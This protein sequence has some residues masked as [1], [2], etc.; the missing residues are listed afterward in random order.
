MLDHVDIWVSGGSGGSGLVSFRR[1]KY[2]PRGGPDGGDGGRGGHVILLGDSSLRTLTVFRRRRRYTGKRGGD[3]GP[4]KRHGANGDDL[5]LHVP[6]GTIVQRVCEGG[7][8][9]VGD[10]ADAGARLVVA[11]GGMGGRGN[12][13]FATSTN[14]APRIAEKGQRGEEAHLILDLK[15]LSDVGIVGM[16]NAGKSTLL[17]RVSRARPKVASYPFTTLEPV[18]GVV[19]IGYES[20]VMADIPGII[21]G[22][23]EGAGL[24]HQFLR[25][26]ERT[27]V[28]VHLVDGTRPQPRGDIETLNAEMAAFNEELARKRQ[29]IVVNKLD[30]P[31]VRERRA[32]LERALTAEG[33]ASL[34][35]SAATGEGVDD[36]LRLLLRVLSAEREA[37]PPAEP[38]VV[39]PTPLRLRFKVT[40]GDHVYRVEGERA[41]AAVEMLGLDSDEAR[42]EVMRQLT[43]MGVVGALRR[44]GVQPGDR[45]HFGS[46]EMEW[47]E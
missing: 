31:E 40:G 6:V 34:F 37:A 47:Q 9:V 27:R 26:V 29:V 1:E 19:E 22:A 20:F 28:L 23:H 4:A 2:V 43:R 3:G 36:L 12:T 41:V 13:R 24:G 17:R 46:V 38:A 39:G 5:V 44:A 14:Q 10:I 35:I 16:P 11:R 21:E 33:A 32:A 18:L 8:E 7:T 42:R 25:H 15:L 45:V 30:L